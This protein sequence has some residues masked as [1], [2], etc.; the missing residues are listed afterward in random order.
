MNLRTI[1]D[2]NDLTNFNQ[3]YEN[4]K[5]SKSSM[6]NATQ[7]DIAGK[8]TRVSAKLSQNAT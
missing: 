7:K 8:G 3:G 4:A 2:E 6:N 1:T 5:Q